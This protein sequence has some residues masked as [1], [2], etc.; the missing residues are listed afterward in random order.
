MSSDKNLQFDGEKVFD[1]KHLHLEKELRRASD[2]ITKPKLNREKHARELI[3][4]PMASEA[5]Y[6]KLKLSMEAQGQS[7]DISHLEIPD[8]VLVTPNGESFHRSGCPS[9]SHA[10]M[11]RP[12]RKLAKCKH[13]F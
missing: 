10:F 8:H 1:S 6:D 13:C 3:G 12:Q 4:R 7:T 11:P 9:L 2:I 5:K